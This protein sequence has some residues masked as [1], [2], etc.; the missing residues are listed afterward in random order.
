MHKSGFNNKFKAKINCR[1]Q[2]LQ[3]LASGRINSTRNIN[4]PSN[5]PNMIKLS[6]LTL[7]N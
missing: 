3:I 2:K 7:Q 1:S 5:N 6:L 4:S